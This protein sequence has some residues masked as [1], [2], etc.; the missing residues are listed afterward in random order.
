MSA[1]LML[2]VTT[3]AVDTRRHAYIYVYMRVIQISGL[4]VSGFEQDAVNPP[5]M[6]SQ[7]VA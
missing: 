5:R 6:T 7:H 1:K 2:G 4:S 3:T